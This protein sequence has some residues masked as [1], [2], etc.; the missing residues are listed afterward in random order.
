ML[1]IK[2]SP[3]QCAIYS[4]EPPNVTLPCVQTPDMV[5]KATMNLVS[6]PLT[7]LRFEMDTAS[8]EPVETIPTEQCAVYPF[9]PE[10]RLRIN[11]LDANGDR[12]WVELTQVPSLLQILFD[13]ADFGIIE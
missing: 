2:D 3:L 5:Y 11:C 7:I 10:N 8:L 9:G 12:L 4:L 1:I 6:A 13:V